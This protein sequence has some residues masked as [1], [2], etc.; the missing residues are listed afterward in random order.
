MLPGVKLSP[1]HCRRY[2]AAEVE[3][4]HVDAEV[5]PRIAALDREDVEAIWSSV[6]YLYAGGTQPA[7]ALCLRRRGHIVLERAI[8]HLYGNAPEDPADA[9]KQPVRYDSL[10]NMF[11]AAK[12]VTAMMAHVLEDQRLLHLDDPIA[13][14]FPE[15]GRNG[16]KNVTVRQILTHRAGVPALSNVA[17]NLDLLADHGRIMQLLC[18]Q[19]PL[20][21]PGRELAYHALTGGYVIGELVRRLTG[22][23]IDVLLDRALRQPLGMKSFTYGVASAQVP[24]VA[25]NA[26]TGAPPLPP[27]STLVK[28]V[29]GV[30]VREA[31]RISNDPRFLTAIIPSGNLV[32]T[33]E[34]GSRFFELLLQGGALDGVRVF[35][36]R[37]V[38]RAI[39]ETS[40]LELDTF[41]GFPI[42]Y[43]S[44]FML[45]GKWASL[46]GPDTPHA[47]GHVGFTNLLAW[48]DPDRDIS[49]CLM[50]TGKPLITP[51]QVLWWNVLRTIAGRCSKIGPRAQA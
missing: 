34:E 7:V 20:S 3:S 27:V 30:N 17:M 45:G 28:R 21:V 1:F 42:R 49:V 22:A 44:G 46:Y 2:P 18:E 41:L 5:D 4:R 12:S 26:F 25:R 40:Y 39:A 31:V 19:K 24:L 51:G 48:A 36:R 8:G 10:F 33:A 37:T 47:F 6:R 35:D 50:T 23:G 9:P 14:Y 13:E 38:H 32:C 16:K 43:G 29:F 11:S 15:F